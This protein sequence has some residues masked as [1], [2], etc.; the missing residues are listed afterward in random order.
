M[1]LGFRTIP[2]SVGLQLLGRCL[3]H[4]QG[5]SSAIVSRHR[6]LHSVR[7]FLLTHDTKLEPRTAG[8]VTLAA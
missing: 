2:Y 1:F 5:R 6:V 7:A 4:K 3:A 8:I